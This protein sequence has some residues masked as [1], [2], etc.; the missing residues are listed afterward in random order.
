MTRQV[1][2]EKEAVYWAVTGYARWWLNYDAGLRSLVIKAGGSLEEDA[3][4][5]IALLYNVA[6]G[7]P[8]K[9]RPAETK[10]LLAVLNQASAD[11]PVSLIDRAK[12]CGDIAT[13]LQVKRLTRN[14]QVSGVTKFMWFLKPDRWTVFDRFAADGMGVSGSLSAQDRMRAFYQALH[15]AG[16]DRTERR[17]Q[18]LIDASP[19]S[20]LPAARI[21]DTLI[22]RREAA[23]N[24][25]GSMATGV[26]S[27]AAISG[28]LD[29]LPQDAAQ[30]LH[31]LASA[32]QTDLGSNVLP[33]A[34]RK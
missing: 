24:R 26:N 6:R 7:L 34:P 17:L 16:F 12:L 30:S 4:A 3:L 29:A 18:Q 13:K 21:L 5:A 28:F 14:H 32:A 2:D 1:P 27:T 8:G 25:Q 9:E 11:W 20:T 15:D 33:I 31:A 10:A 19:W 22:M 23:R